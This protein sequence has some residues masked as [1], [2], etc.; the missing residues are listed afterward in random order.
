MS[1]GTIAEIIAMLRDLHR[2]LDE[3]VEDE[4][5][6]KNKIQAVTERLIKAFPDDNLDGHRL[7][8]AER[9]EE[10]ERNKVFAA[11]IKKEI[12]KW[13]VVGLLGFFLTAMFFYLKHLFKA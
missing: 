3:H 7:Y 10:A 8:H 5:V 2:K 11:E 12:G 6:W 13:G 9:M 4:T 1:D